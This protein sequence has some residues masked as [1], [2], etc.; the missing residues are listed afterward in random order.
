MSRYVSVC[1]RYRVGCRQCV[2]NYGGVDR[3]RNA[4]IETAV[5]PGVLFSPRPGIAL[6]VGYCVVSR[7][8]LRGADVICD[9]RYNDKLTNGNTDAQGYHIGCRWR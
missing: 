4:I 7:I 5:C 8:P 1:D 6:A 2:S 3:D 9:A